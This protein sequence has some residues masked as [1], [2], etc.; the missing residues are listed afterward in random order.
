M[1]KNSPVIEISPPPVPSLGPGNSVR[2]LD[3]D[4]PLFVTSALLAASN[5]SWSKVKGASRLQI[6]LSCTTFYR[7]PTH[8]DLTK[9]GQGDWHFFLHFHASCFLRGGGMSGKCCLCRCCCYRY[10][11]PAALQAFPLCAAL[12]YKYPVQKWKSP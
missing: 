10:Y 5:S 3:L 9:G 12:S 6:F 7:Q 11:A 4:L 8:I 1:L 2:G